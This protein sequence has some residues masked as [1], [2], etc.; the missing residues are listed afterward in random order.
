M[1]RQT[2][3]AGQIPL[4]TD[5]LNTNKYAMVAIAKLAA[6]VLG[7][8]TLVNGLACV[9]TGPAS[10]QVVV[11]PGEIYSLVAT[12]ATAY[13]SL[14]A[15]AHNI[16]K[17][18]ISL[19]DVLLTCTPPGTSGQSINYLVQAIYQDSDTGLV[20]LPYYNASNPSQAYAGPNNS[21]AQQATARKGIVVISAKPGIAATT[22]TQTTPAPDAGYTGLWVVTV[23][24]GQ[25]TITSGNIT[26]A[27]G[28]P[29][30]TERLGDKI[31]ATTG[32]GRYAPQHG[33]CRL[34][35][36]GANVVLLPYNGNKLV[37]NGVMQAIPGAGVSLAPTGL[38]VS[39]VYYVY[40]Y[41]NG[42]VM[43]LEASTT[44]HSTDST[45]GVEI[46]TGDATRTLVGMVR[47]ITGPAF[48]DTSAQRFVRTW[49]NDPGIAGLS[50]FTANRQTTST[51]YVEL[52]SEIR[53]EF[54]CWSG[55]VVVVGGSGISSQTSSGLNSV[56][57]GFDGISNLELGS[58]SA[59][60]VGA[61]GGFAV[62][63]TINL[64]KPGLSEG[65]H[66]VTLAGKVQSGTGTWSGGT[67]LPTTPD[68]CTLTTYIR[69]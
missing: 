18:G 45:T 42:A 47:P 38:T 23:A 62:P 12:D 2:V 37:I 54:L 15:D 1:D 33:Q 27:S 21:G 60:Y 53:N 67:T 7:T 4:E 31:S 59:G 17:Q 34:S 10:L 35:K 49:F 11:N 68:Q 22:G 65:Y 30:I 29:F 3:Y 13:S 41:M 40:A 25:T 56:A 55:E 46:K 43:T 26:K 50:S 14:S 19:D 57:V 24:N 48:Q 20:T 28:A 36:S 6:A 66:Y 58:Y 63:Y 44:G 61:A 39:T 32:D 5:L 51:S 69:K 8:S 9:P 16:L 64:P 52:H